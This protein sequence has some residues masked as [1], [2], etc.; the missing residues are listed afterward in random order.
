MAVSDVTW[1]GLRARVVSRLPAGAPPRLIVVLAHGYGAPASDLV[2]LAQPLYDQSPALEAAALVFPAGCLDLS[3]QGLPGGRAWWPIDLERLIYRPTPDVLARFRR[4]CPEG[5]PAASAHLAALV[6]EAGRQWGVGSERFIL[7]GF[8]QGSMLATDVALRL[9]EPPAGLCI[10]SGGLTNE[11]QWRDLTARRGRLRVFQSHGHYDSILPYPMGVALRDL[12]Q[13]A[14]ADV[15][16]FGFPGDHEI[17]LE[18]ISRLGR[19]LEDRLA[20]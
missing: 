13:E 3:S 15:E 19:W 14:G 4:D 6:H 12:L 16:F 9:P 18:V 8:S 7:G 10:L 11:I 20:E 5:L 17:P 2:G 1:G